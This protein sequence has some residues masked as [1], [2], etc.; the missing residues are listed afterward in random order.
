MWPLSHFLKYMQH[1]CSQHHT[2]YYCTNKGLVAKFQDKFLNSRRKMSLHP[3]GHIFLHC[4]LKI[5]WWYV[6]SKLST[7]T[8]WC[9][10]F[11]CCH[12]FIW[13]INCLTVQNKAFKNEEIA[14]LW[15]FSF[16]VDLCVVK[17]DNFEENQI[18]WVSWLF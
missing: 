18:S 7:T 2:A 17:T 12:V 8:K 14:K 3:P 5:H 13:C 4:I 16:L 6:L 9:K 1:V 10:L 11:V 15:D